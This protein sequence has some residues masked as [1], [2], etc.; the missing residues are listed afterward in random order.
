MCEVNKSLES[1]LTCN[2]CKDTFPETY[3]N[4]SS[5]RKIKEKCNGN[6]DNCSIFD[7]V[8]NCDI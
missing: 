5:K 6:C 8:D 3:K 1:D 7:L 2:E 4:C